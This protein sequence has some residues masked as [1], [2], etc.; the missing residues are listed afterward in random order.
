MPIW[1]RI[2]GCKNKSDKS[3]KTKKKARRCSH[4]IVITHIGRQAT[5][6]IRQ[7]YEAMQQKS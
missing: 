2:T 4:L 1:L 7:A 5:S 3:S 6:L